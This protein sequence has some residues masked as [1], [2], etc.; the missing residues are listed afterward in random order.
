MTDKIA[1]ENH[2]GYS[3]L[4]DREREVLK[5]FAEGKSAKEIAFFIICSE[6]TVD[7]HRKNIMDKLGLEDVNDLLK[8][9]P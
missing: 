2:P 9:A 1:P 3:E 8:F 5:Y 7:I 4:T 6:R